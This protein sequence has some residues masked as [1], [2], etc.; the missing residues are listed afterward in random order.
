MFGCHVMVD[1]QA[2]I[3]PTDG[4]RPFPLGEIEVAQPLP[5]QVMPRQVT[6]RQRN[7]RLH[8]WFEGTTGAC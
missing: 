3:L 8:V 4:R 7:R 2:P 5:V 6:T 1:I